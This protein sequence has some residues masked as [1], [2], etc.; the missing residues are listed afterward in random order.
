MIAP[1][2]AETL[3]DVEGGPTLEMLQ[4]SIGGGH[5]EVVPYFSTVRH[6][7]EIHRCH[8]RAASSRGLPNRR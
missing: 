4:S 7:N 5:I 2:G 8:T 6:D 3:Q 1:D